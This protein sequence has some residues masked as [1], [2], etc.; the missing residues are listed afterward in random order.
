M[1]Q[2]VGDGGRMPHKAGYVSGSK[3]LT[4]KSKKSKSLA[5]PGFKSSKGKK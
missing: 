5:V 2:T 3:S 1:A 4:G